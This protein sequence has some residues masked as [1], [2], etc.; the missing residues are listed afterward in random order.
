MAKRPLLLLRPN[1]SVISQHMILARLYSLRWFIAVPLL[2]LAIWLALPFLLPARGLNRA[3]DHLIKT[4]ENRDPT[5]LQALLA[6]DYQDGFNQDR[7]QVSALFSTVTGQF[8]SLSI[9]REHPAAHVDSDRT[10]HTE[11]LIRINGHGT[12]IAEMIVR[13]SANV[14]T[15]TTFR[16]HRRSWKPWDW[17]L[18]SID[19]PAVRTE[20]MQMRRQL[21]QFDATTGGVLLKLP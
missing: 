1:T 20:V 6:D 4:I 11:A 7:A 14:T 2:A 3:W 15:P 12:P 18:I 13:G 5:A 10:G 17:Q 8:I 9:R 16:W 19:N 21:Q